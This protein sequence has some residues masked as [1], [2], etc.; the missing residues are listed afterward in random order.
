VRR[1][2][3]GDDE[4][5]PTHVIVLATLAAAPRP[6]RLRRGGAQAAG[7]DPAPSLVTRATIIDVASPLSSE[8]AAGWL[9]DAGEDALEESLSVLNWALQAHR[10]AAADPALGHVDRR[11]ALSARVGFGAGDEVAE[12]HWSEARELPAQAARRRRRRMLAPE[13]RLAAILTG[14]EE[15]LVSEELALRARLDLDAGRT[16]HAALQMLIVL[17]AA[18]AELSVDG[19]AGLS[20]RIEELRGHREMVGR[21]AQSALT[22]EPAPEEQSALAEALGRVEAA[23]RARAAA[24]A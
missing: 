17:D 3:G 22:G 15:P 12:G 1:S 24:R 4:G 6:S 18:I 20:E 2:I 7:G 9:R 21:A 8:A 16:R 10:I 13:G 5:P 23:L 14:R 19:A 11:Q